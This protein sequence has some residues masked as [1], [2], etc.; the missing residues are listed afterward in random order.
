MH[1]TEAR[2]RAIK[3]RLE[4]LREQRG[5]TK[6]AAYNAAGISRNSYEL[7]I[8]GGSF[9]LREIIRLADFY[10]VPLHELLKAA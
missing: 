6:Q 7:K 1:T 4:A 3:D 5:V 8:R 9:S 10:E 2:E